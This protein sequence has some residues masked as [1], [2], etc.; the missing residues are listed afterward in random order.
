MEPLVTP[1]S[2]DSVLG[3]HFLPA[4]L[5]LRVQI[6]ILASEGYRMPNTRFQSPNGDIWGG[7]AHLSC[8][9][10]RVSL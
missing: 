3:G 9:Q 1:V 5:P 8:F 7:P 2:A 4:P 6:K 10:I